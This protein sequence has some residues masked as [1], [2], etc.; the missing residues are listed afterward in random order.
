MS[1]RIAR[2]SSTP[3]PSANVPDA[4]L[5]LPADTKA[6]GEQQW[7]SRDVKAKTAAALKRLA[8]SSGPLSA[9]VS[10]TLANLNWF[11]WKRIRAPVTFSCWRILS[12]GGKSWPAAANASERMLEAAAFVLSNMVGRSEM[13]RSSKASSAAPWVGCCCADIISVRYARQ[14]SWCIPFPLE[15]R[16]SGGS[17][18]R[19][20]PGATD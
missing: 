1:A 6:V 5:A 14:R 15:E 3:S 19:G 11:D 20:A 12:T 9:P 8:A 18:N 16:T 4:N 7:L 10:S 13:P 2:T 17:S